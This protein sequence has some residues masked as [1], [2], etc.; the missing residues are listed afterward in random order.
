M[1]SFAHS[2]PTFYKSIVYLMLIMF[3][4]GCATTKQLSTT[5]FTQVN[6]G[7]E[8]TI[9]KTN[10]KV[11]KFIV[12][13]ILEDGIGGSNQLVAYTDI[14]SMHRKRDKNVARSVV[15]ALVWIA[16]VAYVTR[17]EDVDEFVIPDEL[18]Q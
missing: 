7:D 17:D 15:L 5:D 1:T 6:L 10:G 14:S 16:I 4:T 2:H 12:T 11:V 18:L 8:I 13:D 3:A 9:T